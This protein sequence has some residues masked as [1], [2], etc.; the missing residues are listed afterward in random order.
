MMLL[1][2]LGQ[3]TPIARDCIDGIVNGHLAIL[4]LQK[5]VN[6]LAALPYNLLAK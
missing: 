6:V 1:K 3:S 2:L 4:D 5:V